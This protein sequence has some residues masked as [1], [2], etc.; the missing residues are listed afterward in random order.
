MKSGQR[1]HLSEL[2]VG[3]IVRPIH[4]IASESVYIP[5]LG[6]K[7]IAPVLGNERDFREGYDTMTVTEVTNEELVFERPY[8]HLDKDGKRSSQGI[9]TFRCNRSHSGLWYELLYDQRQ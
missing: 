7:R 6:E 1:V 8:L 9:E 3:D 2:R 4:G 5:F